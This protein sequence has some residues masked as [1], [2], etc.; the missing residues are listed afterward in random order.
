MDIR[1][2]LILAVVAA[3]M[4]ILGRLAR[5]GAGTG[6]PRVPGADT[7]DPSMPRLE[8]L[9]WLPGVH[10]AEDEPRTAREPVAME[11]PA[12][13]RGPTRVLEPMRV[14]EPAPLPAPPRPTSPA[15]PPDGYRDRAPRPVVVRS[16]E[17]RPIEPRR[18]ARKPPAVDPRVAELAAAGTEELRRRVQEPA[19]APSAVRVGAAPAAGP[20]DRLG[21]GSKEGLR[22]LVVAREVLGPPLALRDVERGQ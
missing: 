18:R 11:E 9:E 7:A 17:P 2:L 19:R 10:E 6:A 20:G 8:D 5:R 12:P 13:V 15:V 4:E 3:I 1:F 22:R 16:R 21:L 14:P